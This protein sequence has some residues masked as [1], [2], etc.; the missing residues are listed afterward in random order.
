MGWLCCC[1]S[2]VALVLPKKC[3]SSAAC[4]QSGAVL[5]HLLADWV[6]LPLLTCLVLTNT[7]WSA[8]LG[9]GQLA[10]LG[11]PLWEKQ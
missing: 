2:A 8:A 7:G 1:S 3:P 11:S 6:V 5:L 9:A 10:D 4:P